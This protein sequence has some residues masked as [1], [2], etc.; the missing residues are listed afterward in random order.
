MTYLILLVIFFYAVD[1]ARI[2]IRRDNPTVLRTTLFQNLND[3]GEYTPQDVGF[4][5]AFGLD[6]PL[7]PE[8]GN[9]TVK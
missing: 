3:A 5:F 8:Y 4:S 2:L 1:N 9:F 7:T 6:L